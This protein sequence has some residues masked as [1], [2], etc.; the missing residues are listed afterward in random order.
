MTGLPFHVA[1]GADAATWAVWSVVIGLAGARWPDER[2]SRD[3]LVTR[4]RP[5]EQD[6]RLY[7]RLGVR[8]WKRW[9]PDF[10]RFGGGRSKRPG[11]TR[12]PTAWRHLE[13][14]SRRAELV[15]WLTLTALP[16]TLIWSGGLLAAAMIAY[17]AVANVPCIAAQ[18]HNRSRLSGLHRRMSPAS[19]SG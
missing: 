2:L 5:R 13:I 15:H 8:R 18:R 9:L 11:R 3:G 17:A 4:L 12:D 6:G 10:G 1:L 14:D 7:R 19:H 16:V